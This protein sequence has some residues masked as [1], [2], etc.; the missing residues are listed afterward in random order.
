M[1]LIKIMELYLNGKLK[2]EVKIPLELQS[3]YFN[4]KGAGTKAA[5]GFKIAEEGTKKLGLEFDRGIYC[6]EAGKIHVYNEDY[7]EN[8]PQL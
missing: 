6:V 2:G 8:G 3:K 5:L 7:M 1:L 4:A